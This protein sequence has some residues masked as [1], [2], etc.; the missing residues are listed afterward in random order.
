MRKLLTLSLRLT[1]I[2]LAIAVAAYFI[3]TPYVLRAPG[4][5][6]DLSDIVTV[7]GGDPHHAGHLYMTTVIYEKANLLFC[8]YS[9]FDRYAMLVP[10]DEAY[11]RRVLAPAMPM[12]GA[13]EDMMRMS[14]DVAKVV[15]LREMGYKIK[16]RSTGARVLGFLDNVPAQAMLSPNDIIDAVNARRVR[17]VKELRNA[18]EGLKA[19]MMVDVTVER[20]GALHVV[21]FPLVGRDGKVLIGVLIEDA[22]ELNKKL[23][24]DITISTHN[25]NGA[26]AGLMFTLEIVDQLTPGGLTHG[27]KVAGTGTIDL[28]GRV[29]PIEGTELKLVAAKR[30]GATVFLVPEEN[31]PDVK[32]MMPEVRIVP[33]R[34]LKEAIRA[35]R[36]LP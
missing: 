34:T 8:M 14:K 35:I 32:G 9:L 1:L 20:D 10:R 3:P 6:D 17:S 25:V 21:R 30:A 31:Y 27:L 5:A 4:H 28:D 18:I 29:G 22:I 2:A 23:P 26:S 11:R 33:V 12:V 16:P 19:G 15:A 24:L 7:Q 36:A 13:P